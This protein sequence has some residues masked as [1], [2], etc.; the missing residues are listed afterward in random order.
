MADRNS[1]VGVFDSGVGGVSVLGQ[2]VR[3]LPRERFIYMGDTA[4][5]PYGTKPPE[6]VL[7]YVRGVMDDLIARDVKAVVIACNTATSVAAATLRAEMTLPIIG[8]E[9]ALK[10][11]AMVR[12]KG[13]ILVL[14]TPMTLCLPKFDALMARYGEGAVRLPC[15]GLME[16]VEREAFD[17]AEVYLREHLAAFDLN[18]VDAIVLGCTHYVFLRPVLQRILPPHVQVMDGNEGTARQLGRVLQQHGLQRLEGEGGVELHTSG[19]E[20]VYIPQMQRLLVMSD[21]LLSQMDK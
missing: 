3:M 18:E 13:L 4:H 14:A 20:T 6:E 9:P 11:A 15:P 17:E 8:M 21:A 12:R 7:G 16:L 2:L 5:A 1:P 10:P 19:D